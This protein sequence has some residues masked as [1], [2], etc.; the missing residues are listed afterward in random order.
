M[1]DD[2]TSRDTHFGYA[3]VA[4]GDKSRLVGQ[5]FDSVADRYDVMNDL[6]SF[7]LH[8]LWKT[9]AV[10]LANIRPGERVLDIATGSGDLARAMARRGAEVWITDINAS[11]LR[12]ATPS[13]CRSGREASS[14]SRS[15]SG[16]AI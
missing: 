7:G 8:R 16:C 14:A 2:D 4:D 12:S 3:R 9:F 15:H 6:M 1:S 13:I 10:T 11:M 5:V